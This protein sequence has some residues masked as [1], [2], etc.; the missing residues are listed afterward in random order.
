MILVILL[1]NEVSP[2]DISAEVVKLSFKRKKKNNS[3][4]VPVVLVKCF[5]SLF[6]LHSSVFQCHQQSQC[7]RNPLM[8]QQREE[9][10]WH[11]PAE[12]LALLSPPFPGTGRLC[13]HIPLACVH[14]QA[15]GKI[16]TV[17]SFCPEWKHCFWI[18][19]ENDFCFQLSWLN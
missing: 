8:P 18:S 2:L 12:P 13:T 9:K 5:S 6:N 16:F 1:C 19:V 3:K 11:F 17:L 10:R 4:N 15:S 14:S 7:L